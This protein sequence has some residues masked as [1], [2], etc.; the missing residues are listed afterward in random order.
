VIRAG[1]LY[2]KD[3]LLKRAGLHQAAWRTARRN[4]LRV[5]EANGRAY[6]RGEDWLAYL[7][8]LFE[9]SEN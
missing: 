7:E 9:A 8:S 2:R 6:V 5:L 4:G 3:E 1:E